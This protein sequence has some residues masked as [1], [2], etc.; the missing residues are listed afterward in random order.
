MPDTDTK[1]D[2]GSAVT[3][4]QISAAKAQAVSKLFDA[5]FT[6]HNNI[7]ALKNDQQTILQRNQNLQGQFEAQQAQRATAH[8]AAKQATDLV[9]GLDKEVGVHKTNLEGLKKGLAKIDEA[10]KAL[11][12]AKLPVDELTAGKAKITAEIA[13]EQKSLDYKSKTS[14]AH[15][16]TAEAKRQ[17]ATASPSGTDHASAAM[18]R[19]QEIATQIEIN[20]K[21]AVDKQKEAE[22]AQGLSEADW[23]KVPE[24]R[25]SIKSLLSEAQ[26]AA[27]K[28][29]DDDVAASAEEA[30]D[31]LVSNDD[32][33]ALDAMLTS[34]KAT[35]QVKG[36]LP[37]A[38][39]GSAIK[40]VQEANHAHQTIVDM[41]T[42]LAGEAGGVDKGTD[43][44]KEKF[45]QDSAQLRQL[46]RDFKK[47]YGSGE[48]L[49]FPSMLPSEDDMKA[50][51]AAGKKVLMSAQV[52]GFL[53]RD[54]GK[55][56]KDLLTKIDQRY[57]DLKQQA[58]KMKSSPEESAD[59]W[60]KE[61]DSFVQKAHAMKAQAKEYLDY[62]KGLGA[63]TKKDDALHIWSEITAL[64]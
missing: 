45:K 56:A 37:G 46:V 41:R 35:V 39:P 51:Q 12:V 53:G 23:F 7:Q 9:A 5:A 19:L 29:E 42:K 13:E 10:I 4:D 44:V 50:V 25:K 26:A 64:G 57:Y 32:M 11:E 16:A 24:N 22:A 33:D 48:S 34:Y 6:A 47:T 8:A 31:L 30:G 2:D 36:R 58:G 52:V 18:Q 15:T 61:V 49:D 38:D 63:A 28:K 1:E 54:V 20:E 59:A 21:A 40:Q 14:E 60:E 17:E 3:P 62:F 43:E 55:Q 27:M